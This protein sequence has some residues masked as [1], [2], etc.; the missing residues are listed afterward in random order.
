MELAP[1][2][3]LRLFLFVTAIIVTVPAAAQVGIGGGFG[4]SVGGVMIDAEGA[5]RAASIDEKQQLGKL[6]REAVK[7]PQGDLA[8]A[9]ELRMVSLKGLQQAIRQHQASGEAIPEA[10][11]FLAGLQRIEYVFVDTVNQDLVIAGPA[12]PWVLREDGSVVGKM[13]G[14]ATLRLE[15]LIVAIRSVESARNGGISCSIEPTEEGRLRLQK[16]LRNVK[17]QPGQNPASLEPAMREAFGPQQVLLTGVPSD[18]HYARTLVAADFEMKRVAMNLVDSQVAGLSSYLQLAKNAGHGASHNP[19]WWMACNY[20][21]LTRSEDSL[22]WKIS[23]QGVKTLTEQDI[24]NDDGS[25]T[26]S[27]RVDKLAQKWADLMT[28]KYTELAQRM[29][30]FGDL[31]NIIDMTVVATLIVQERLGERAG[32][33]L[34]VLSGTEDAIELATYPAPKSIQ[35]QCSFIRGRSGWVVT[36]SGGVDVNAFSVVENQTTDNSIA[37]VRQTALTRDDATRWWWNG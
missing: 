12:E 7:L 32:I 35:P 30:V 29:P 6:L 23:G 27:G 24:V 10:I 25:V 8:E 17:L 14:N 5:V 1:V 21:A 36:A 37:D 18:T 31:R 9:A 4:R 2:R 26:E 3:T 33:D 22:A 28:E 20:D 13:S 19:R 34:A 11:E 15:D 16:L